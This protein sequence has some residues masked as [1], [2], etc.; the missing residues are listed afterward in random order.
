MAGIRLVRTAYFDEPSILSLLERV[1]I[2]PEMERVWSKVETLQIKP[3]LFSNALV[4]AYLG[5]QGI[6]KKTNKEQMEWAA[7]VER[8]ALELADLIEFTDVDYH[9]F[10]GFKKAH[11]NFILNRAAIAVISPA[12]GCDGDSPPCRI[13][14]KY[15]PPEISKVLR[16]LPLISQEHVMGRYKRY[17]VG[18]SN[19]IPLPRPGK[20]E[21]SHSYF[22]RYLSKFFLK[23]TEGKFLYREYVRICAEVAYGRKFTTRQIEKIANRNSLL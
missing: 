23:S 20:D 8:L 15:R 5:P 19:N 13:D 3:E 1:L 10:E 21:S 11:T 22:I 6:E 7:S 18:V 16:T 2:K 14:I 17:M 12:C 4:L 9:L